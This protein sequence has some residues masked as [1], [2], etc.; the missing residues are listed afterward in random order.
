MR[1]LVSVCC[2]A[3]NHAP[4][5][6]KALDGI[7]MQKTSFP[8]EVIIHDDV[9]TDGTI[10]II[11]EYAEQYPDI[12]KPIF[13][14]ENQYSKNVPITLN[15][16]YPRARGKYIATC[17]CDDYWTDCNKLEKQILYM[18][19]HPECSCTA[20]AVNYIEN[21]EITRNDRRSA[22]ECDF[23][24]E[25]VIS[26]GGAFVAT[27][28]LCFRTEYACEKP[29]WR[30]LA[31]NVGDYPSQILFSLKGKFHYFPM[32]MG[33]Y[34]LGHPGSWTEMQRHNISA[35]IENRSL[36]AKWLNELNRETG[37]KYRHCICRLIGGDLN[38]LYKHNALEAVEFK[39][40]MKEYKFDVRNLIFW[41]MKIFLR[42]LK[43]GTFGW[44]R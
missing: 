17:E 44:N 16:L 31:A 4:Y 10:D 35:S 29:K 36:E 3:Y 34:R 30:M 38:Y 15:I 23:T 20:H 5:I 6:H 21:G 14:E 9:S 12:I 25:Q 2:L 28:S 13:E 39:R 1:P 33:R 22:K 18:E 40:I 26:G 8:F 42:K 32:I 7:L 19:K 11:K 24:P 27:C 41:K 37:F 43:R